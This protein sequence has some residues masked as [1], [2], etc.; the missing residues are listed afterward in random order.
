MNACYDLQVHDFLQTTFS[1]IGN[2]RNSPRLSV[3]SVKPN[4]PRMQHSH[5]FCAWHTLTTQ[6]LSGGAEGVRI[7]NPNLWECQEVQCFKVPQNQDGT[8][9]FGLITCLVLYGELSFLV[10][11]LP[12][13]AMKNKVGQN[14]SQHLGCSNPVVGSDKN[15]ITMLIVNVTFMSV[16]F[17]N[18]IQYL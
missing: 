6:R 15:T 16:Y 4:T 5:S 10:L 9:F 8:S 2:L 12:V 13:S 3:H 1:G 7:V 17:F 18:E 11:T 14:Q